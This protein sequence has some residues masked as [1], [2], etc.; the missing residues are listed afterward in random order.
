MADY[1]QA[2]KKGLEAAEPADRARK[3]IDSVFEDLD[4]QIRAGTEGRIGIKRQEFIIQRMPFTAQKLEDL[5]TPK[6]TYW[7]IVA[8]NPQITSSPV[9]EL[10]RWR[11]DRAGYPCKISWGG[12]EHTC[13]DKRS[14]ENVLGRLLGD[15]LVGETLHVLMQVKEKTSGKELGDKG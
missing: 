6:E 4:R 3:E 7:A 2:F 12:M 15:P 9:K 1:I 11:H 13:E 5:I 14:L 10:S 8:Y